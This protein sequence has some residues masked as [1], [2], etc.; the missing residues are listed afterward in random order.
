MSGTDG[1]DFAP[2]DRLLGK[3]QGR[4]EAFKLQM[5]VILVAVDDPLSENL[6]HDLPD[7]LGA[8]ALVTRDLVIGP[9]VAQ[10]GE[11]AL[12]PGGPADHI[13]PPPFGF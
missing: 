7:A 4:A 12:R 2:L 10:P 1:L 3:P 5:G 13:R 6:G 11:D 9:A 8:Q